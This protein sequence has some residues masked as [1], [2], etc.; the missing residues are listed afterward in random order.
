MAYKEIGSAN[1]CMS[2]RKKKAN[3]KR[4]WN[5]G[6]TYVGCSFSVYIIRLDALVYIHVDYKIP[7]R[8]GF[9]DERELEFVSILSREL[10]HD[11]YEGR[12][13][14]RISTIIGTRRSMREPD[15]TYCR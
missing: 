13:T 4:R 15:I 1:V 11:I 9:K 8:V 6:R 2:R 7:K 10:R 3:G 14:A 12:P 5:V